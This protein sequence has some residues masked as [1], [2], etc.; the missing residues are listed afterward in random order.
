M[1][2]YLTEKSQKDKKTNKDYHHEAKKDIHI[3]YKLNYQNKSCIKV[4]T[5]VFLILKLKYE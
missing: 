2:D 5:R 3:K 1:S 4:G